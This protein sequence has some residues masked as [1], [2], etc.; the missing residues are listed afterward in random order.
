[1]DRRLINGLRSHPGIHEWTAR[2]LR[3][4]GLQ[5]YLI[6]SDIEN[7]REDARVAYRVEIFNDHLVDGETRRGRVVLPL[8]SA[9]L[10]RLHE[11]LDSA[12]TMA[13]LVHNPTWQL[14][15]AAP[16]AEVPLADPRL[17]SRDGMLQASR[18]A[19][20]LIREQLSAERASGVRLSAAELFLDRVDE[21]LETSR[22]A[23]AGG[24][25]THVLLE[26]TLLAHHGDQD[27]EH[28]SQAESRR[29]EDVDLSQVLVHGAQLARDRAGAGSPRTRLGPVLVDE[30]ALGQLMGDSVVG[31]L[32]AYLNQADAAAEYARISRFALGKQVFLGEQHNGDRFDARANA[33]HPFGVRSYRVDEDGVP[34]RDLSI[35]ED[36]V[37]V[38]RPATARYARY[39]EVPVTGRAGM[40]EVAPGPTSLAELR[41]SDEPM[42]RIV[43]F[44]SANVDALSGDFGMEIR[45]GYEVGPGGERPVSGGSVTGNL[46]RAMA[47]ARFARETATFAAYAGPAA[48]RFEAMQVAGGD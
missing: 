40:L 25:L 17:L 14:P 41:R 35:I 28:F 11:V 33:T 32:G 46:F 21:E 23:V 29:L 22:G 10:D 45:L 6:G 38:A 34:A 1:M 16:V 24:T 44:S 7:V 18:E 26:A 43:A 36:G 12:V 19:A 5:T 31:G 8:T 2:E 47:S 13:G 15:D 42:Y 37:L 39:V 3:S 27:A 20:E 4:E 9:D 30:S 48:I